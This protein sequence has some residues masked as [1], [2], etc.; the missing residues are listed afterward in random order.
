MIHDHGDLG[1]PPRELIDPILH[2]AQWS[3][4]Q[5]RP[6][7]ALL[8]KKSQKR[9]QLNRLPQT[10]FIGQNPVEPD[11]IEARQPGKPFKLVVTHLAAGDEFGL[12]GHL[13]VSCFQR[14]FELIHDGGGKALEM[15]YDISTRNGMK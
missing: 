10:H 4:D 7:G 14:A 3:Q 2:R 15:T 8:T 12:F 13:D 1:S 11:L 6:V 5:E 9:D